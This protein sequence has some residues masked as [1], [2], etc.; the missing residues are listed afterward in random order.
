MSMF[1]ISVQLVLYPTP[2][3]IT[4]ECGCYGELKR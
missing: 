3:G 2:L 1:Y 4:H